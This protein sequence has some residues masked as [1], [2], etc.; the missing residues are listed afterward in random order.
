MPQIK[1]NVNHFTRSR[2]HSAKTEAALGL[3]VVPVFA[4]QSIKKF[5]LIISAVQP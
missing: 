3:S 5:I 1:I 2:T 4:Y